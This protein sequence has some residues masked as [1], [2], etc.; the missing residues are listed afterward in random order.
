MRELIPF[1]LWVVLCGVLVIILLLNDVAHA[2]WI[3]LGI[4]VAPWVIVGV[5]RLL[6]FLIGLPFEAILR[7]NQDKAYLDDANRY[8]VNRLGR[9]VRK[10]IE[11]DGG[12]ID[13]PVERQR[14]ADIYYVTIPYQFDPDYDGHQTKFELPSGVIL[15]FTPPRTAGPSWN[16]IPVPSSLEIEA[17]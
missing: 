4:L 1:F 9:G 13:G 11:Q 16:R 10:A 12:Q 8:E 5:L 15:V 17:T 7:W 6:L 14:L 3:G 2:V